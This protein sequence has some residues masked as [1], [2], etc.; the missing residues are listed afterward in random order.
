MIYYLIYYPPLMGWKGG[1]KKFQNFKCIIEPSVIY[2]W[3]AGILRFLKTYYTICL[4]I[5][6][7]PLWA[8]KGG[9]NF[10]QNFKCIIEPSV[11]HDW[12]AGV[13]RFLKSYYTICLHFILY[14]SLHFCEFLSIYERGYRGGEAKKIKHSK[15]SYNKVWYTI[16]K[17][18][19]WGFWKH[20][21]Q[22]VCFFVN[23]CP[24]MRGLPWGGRKKIQNCHRNK[25]WYTIG[26]LMFK[27]NKK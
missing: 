7:P 17:L 19:F 14:N 16:G 21:I 3:K 27:V 20:I 23:I 24:F 9:G 11:I 1:I 8:G 2:H 15:L 18:M 10:F 26:K 22:Y 4:G 12:K 5:I 25:V 6:P 13:L